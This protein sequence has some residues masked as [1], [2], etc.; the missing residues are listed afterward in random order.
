MVEGLL[1][2]V[3][4]DS[5]FICL[6][7]RLLGANISYGAKID[8]VSLLSSWDLITIESGVSIHG[9]AMYYHCNR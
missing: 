2:V 3:M 9:Q 1:R 6:W 8:G 4:K 7:Y 5:V